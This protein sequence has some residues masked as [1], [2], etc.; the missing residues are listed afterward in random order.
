MRLKPA[1]RPGDKDIVLVADEGRRARGGVDH[2]VCGRGARDHTLV[3]VDVSIWTVAPRCLDCKSVF[4][5][6][7]FVW[8]ET[9]LV[10]GPQGLHLDKPVEESKY[11]RDWQE[12]YVR[13]VAAEQARELDDFGE[14][15]PRDHQG[16]SG[17]P[18]ED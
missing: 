3:V 15:I 7:E 11:D 17:P 9:Y 1:W 13:R 12:E 6:P 14:H 16:P 5:L 2:D 8:Q 10:P 18:S 4:E